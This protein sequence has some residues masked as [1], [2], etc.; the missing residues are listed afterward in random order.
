MF[1][2][3]PPQYPPGYDPRTVETKANIKFNL[4]DVEGA[5]MA[6]QQALLDWVDDA[7][8]ASSGDA[9][10][11]TPMGQAIADLWIS[12]ANLNRKANKVGAGA[13]L[14]AISFISLRDLLALSNT[15]M[16]FVTSFLTPLFCSF[17]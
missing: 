2:A 5:Q 13:Q 14:V 12:F 8:E 15:L 10:P 17:S 6:Y 1:G 16:L 3:D 7:R 9:D 11:A 4:G